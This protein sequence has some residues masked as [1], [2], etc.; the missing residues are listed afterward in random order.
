MDQFFYPELPKEIMVPELD[1]T[2]HGK[3]VNVPMAT[4]FKQVVSIPVYVASR[5]DAELGEQLLREGKL[6][7]VGLARRLI[8]DPEYPNK[9]AA[10]KLEDIAVCTGDLYCWE[11]RGSNLPIKCRINAC[12]GREY[13]YEIK[14]AAKKKKVMIVG[15]GPAGMEA[16]RVAALSG[17]QVTLYDKK[18][19]LGGGLPLA[20]MVKGT[21]MEDFPAFVRYFKVQLKKLGVQVKLRK[22]VNEA[23]VKKVQPDVLILAAGGVATIP[24]IPGNKS[25]NVVN[26]SSMDRLLDM[27]IWFCGPNLTRRLTKIWMPIGKK[28]V[29]IG[30]N[31][32]GCELAE[33]MVKT[34]RKASVPTSHPAS[35]RD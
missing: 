4:M 29:V 22:E 27:L 6:D 19:Y 24:E 28:V 3:G 11:T 1:W 20:A 16:A 14:P 13:E 30:G 23:L 8:A 10:G 21:E 9:V 25:G 32:H 18:P 15:G 12:L 5:L 2:R 34:G 17:H 26:L 33:Y 31:F 35:V 7:F